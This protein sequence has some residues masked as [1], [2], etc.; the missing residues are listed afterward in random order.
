MHCILAFYVFGETIAK[1]EGAS[2]SDCRT[3]DSCLALLPP[4]AALV[5]I[6]RDRRCQY[7]LS[8]LSVVPFRLPPFYPSHL[9]LRAVPCQR[10][11]VVVLASVPGRWQL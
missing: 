3:R 11:K 7:N 9:R 4:T 10:F 2:I 5:S 6:F 1:Q 8:C